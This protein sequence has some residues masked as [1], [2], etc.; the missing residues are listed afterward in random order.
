MANDKCEDCGA[1]LIKIVAC[2]DGENV[3]QREEPSGHI[4]GG[5]D[6]VLIEDLRVQLA[7]ARQDA[8]EEAA[9][10]FIEMTGPVPRMVAEK[11]RRMADE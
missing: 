6:C 8:L 1:E 2:T 3:Q 5:L 10:R 7:T 4:R 11:L 9:G